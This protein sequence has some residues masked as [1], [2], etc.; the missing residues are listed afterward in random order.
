[1]VVVQLLLQVVCVVVAVALLLNPFT[2]P[3]M[4]AYLAWMYIDRRPMRGGLVLSGVQAGRAWVRRAVWWRYMRDYFPVRLVK[5]AELSAER[6]YIFG[7]HPHGIL[8]CAF[9]FS[10]Y[11]IN[12]SFVDS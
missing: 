2:F 8:R 12:L 3:F 6:H 5:T 4:L 9:Y 7:Y 1:V 10:Y 11:L